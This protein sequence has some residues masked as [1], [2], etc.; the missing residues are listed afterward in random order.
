MKPIAEYE[1]VDIAYPWRLRGS[2]YNQDDTKGVAWLPPSYKDGTASGTRRARGI[3]CGYFQ[4]QNRSGSSATVGIGVRI[5][6]DLWIAG[7]WVNAAGTPYTDD[8]TDAQDTGTA[9][10]ALETTTNNDGFVV[11]SKVPFNAISIDVGTASDHSGTPARAIRYTDP[12]GDGWINFANTLVFDGSA[13][14]L[15]AT[16]TTD[17]NESL[18]VWNVP[19]DWGKTQASGL[20]GIPGDYYAVNVRATTAPDTT[21]AVADSISIYRLYWV[22]EGLGDN[23]VYEF[24]PGGGEFFM[25]HGDALVALFGTANNQNLV[26][27]LVRTRG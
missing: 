5:P 18:I 24:Y 20:S 9:D 22:I 25:P 12:E 16:G 8:T 26:R 17:A 11:A 2:S 4:I 10:F 1:T 19:A 14:E 6:N 7:Q 27:A 23:Q 3:A 13:A 21:A 15:S